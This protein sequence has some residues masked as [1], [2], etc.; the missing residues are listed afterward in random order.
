MFRMVKNMDTFFVSSTFSDMHFERDAIRDKITPKLNEVA[1]NYGEYISF[2]DLR[3]GVNTEYLDSDEGM[4]KVLRVCLREIDR[5]QPYM[6]VILGNRYGHSPEPKLLLDALD[7]STNFHGDINIDRLSITALEILYGA[8][9][10]EQVQRTLFYFRDIVGDVEEIPKNYQ[11]EDDEG[12]RK[13]LELLKQKIQENVCKYNG[14]LRVYHA[15]WNSQKKILEIDEFIN[16]IIEDVQS[17]MQK[18]WVKNKP[19]YKQLP[20]RRLEIDQRFQTEIA[21]QKA[22]QCVMRDK[23]I[24]EYID[25]IRG[26]DYIFALQGAPG[27]GKSTIISKLAFK[28]KAYGQNV[29]I[30]L[31]GLTPMTTTASNINHYIVNW[32]SQELHHPLI[33]EDKLPLDRLHDALNTWDLKSKRRLIVL[34]DGI[35]M[36]SPDEFRDKLL[37]L[38]TKIYKRTRFVLSCSESFSLPGSIH[39]KKIHPIDIN[40]RAF[41]ISGILSKTGR[42]LG[43]EVIRGILN[44]KSANN[45]LYIKLLI[46]RLLMMNRLDFEEIDKSVDKMESINNYQLQIIQ[47]CPD[48]LMGL[49]LE[50]ISV[51]FKRVDSDSVKLAINYITLSEH[52]LRE[53]D[54]ENILS[55]H[56]IKW[57][58]LDF[59][60]FV[61]YLSEFFIQLDD[62]RYD[63]ANIMI[64]K[65]CAKF[66]KKE[67]NL[68]NNLLIHFKNLPFSDIVRQQEIIMKCIASRNH[69]CFFECIVELY[70]KRDQGAIDFAT[71]SI[72]HSLIIA[73]DNWI[74]TLIDKTVFDHPYKYFFSVNWISKFFWSV[75]YL[76]CKLNTF[77]F[78]HR[79]IY[80]IEILIKFVVND[81]Y[82]KLKIDDI[83]GETSN[84]L[85]RDFYQVISNLSQK[86]LGYTGSINHLSLYTDCLM[87]CSKMFYFSYNI[88][89][90]PNYNHMSFSLHQAAL[91]VNWELLKSECTTKTFST[92]IAN[93]ENL[94]Q[95]ALR[96]W[97]EKPLYYFLGK[98]TGL[99]SFQWDKM[100][101]QL[102][103]SA[104]NFSD[105]LIKH[106]DSDES[107]KMLAH[108]HRSFGSYYAM[109]DIYG[110]QDEFRVNNSALSHY[111]KSLE[112]TEQLMLKDGV[113]IELASL[114]QRIG[115][116]YV[117]IDDE[118]GIEY[119]KKSVLQYERETR[120][121]PSYFLDAELATSLEYL[122]LAYTRTAYPNH[123]GALRLY[124]KS[125][126]I[127]KRLFSQAS[128]VQNINCINYDCLQIRKLLEETGSRGAHKSKII[129]DATVIL[130]KFHD[131][132]P[133]D[134][135][136]K[137][138]NSDVL[139]NL[140]I[141]FF[142]A[143]IIDLKKQLIHKSSENELDSIN[144]HLIEFSTLFKRY[145]FYKMNNANIEKNKIGIELKLIAKYTK[146]EDMKEI[147]KQLQ[148]MFLKRFFTE[149]DID[150]FGASPIIGEILK[151]IEN[152][153]L[154]KLYK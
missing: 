33:S 80:E 92:L 7:D 104:L 8:L 4:R 77:S 99:K 147:L 132:S 71:R 42:Q 48:N 79:S 23:E 98:Y 61:N 153:L 140:F 128:N 110:Y 93:C 121:N 5:C 37:F 135:Y 62:G 57:S 151:I 6:I 56:G 107:Y 41:V 130:E 68:Q 1:Q 74:I 109:H 20:L 113:G 73:K 133:C 25:I 97:R 36:L 82:T 112:Y 39:T 91:C 58:A 50:I 51:A 102:L 123:M 17:L 85:L 69:E 106:D 45:P 116:L 32:I 138:I 21:S 31:C 114:F 122:A 89:G 13:R 126:T 142:H 115:F 149:D 86:L 38:P 101:L 95:T 27:I 10:R 146:K 154:Y 108:V 125:L 49:C 28:L 40:N 148:T 12:Q 64:K 119:L 34:I 103:N 75:K 150:N 143:Q 59:S 84:K 83:I 81:I 11:S 72:L 22:S 2:C 118:K 141:D 66:I 137:K 152:K 65:A 3:W 78:Y 29:L 131:I 96:I 24:K 120:L 54:L 30:I 15:K 47:S 100:S 16:Y 43:C 14:H 9:S 117:D 88:K 129:K 67:R 134:K 55:L 127:R 105:L 139:L 26:S 94:S 63:F 46:H 145:Y 70:E 44:K 144:K 53:S 76:L 124:T 111:E 87:C 19:K 60:L 90:I 52:G 18:K 136:K 35:D